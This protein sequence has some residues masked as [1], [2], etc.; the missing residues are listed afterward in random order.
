MHADKS[1][2]HKATF[3][4]GGLY[5]YRDVKLDVKL[6][7]IKPLLCVQCTQLHLEPRANPH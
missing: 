7:I 5:S 3:N 1:F 6:T 4:H 2:A